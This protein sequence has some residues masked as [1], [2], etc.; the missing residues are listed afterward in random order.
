MSDPE[1]DASIQIIEEFFPQQQNFIPGAENL[2]I[3]DNQ[4]E[5]NI[6][7]NLAPALI[8]PPQPAMP[9]QV[10]P[11]NL[12]ILIGMMA[13]FAGQLDALFDRITV[14]EQRLLQVEANVAALDRIRRHA[15]VNGNVAPAALQDNEA[16]PNQNN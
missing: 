6:I 8:V 5:D 3:N 12:E 4:Q 13:D 14:L 1:S 2:D 15:L 16:Q 11:P 10:N 7:Q 9:A